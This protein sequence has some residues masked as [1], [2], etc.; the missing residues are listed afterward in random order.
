MSSTFDSATPFV[1]HSTEKRKARLDWKSWL[2]VGARYA[3]MSLFALFFA[4]PFLWMFLASFK[5]Q[6][7]IFQY[8]FPLSWKTFIPQ[9]WTLENFQGL[10]QLEPYPFT[11]Y[12]FNSLFV[13]VAV[14]LGSLVVNSMAAYAFA[15]LKFPGQN[16]LF[17]IFLSTTI[18]PFEVI[19][20]P[21]YLEMKTF[22]WVNSYQALIV[23]WIANAMGIFLLRQF[24]AEIPRD[25]I[26][27]AQIDGCSHLSA[28]RKI[29]L[30]NAIP[31]MITFAL[32]RF[33]ASW[34][35]FFW[36]LIV[37]PSP[38]KRVVQVAIATFA[39]EAQTRWGLTFA[40]TTL[41]TLPII[42]A[43]VL[44]QRYYVQGVMTSGMKG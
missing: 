33:Q 35:A 42:V 28:F 11:H 39:T 37:A 21:L 26:E 10:M 1:S 30:P 8:I 23:P 44:L 2:G 40:A 5:P 25:L 36:P 6:L 16:A 9:T 24:F 15:K 38:E 12:I 43:F 29:V 41:A 34:D 20:I 14:T 3:I 7:E 13:A 19:A 27:A 22:S 32:I 31:A 18:I 4:V 17:A